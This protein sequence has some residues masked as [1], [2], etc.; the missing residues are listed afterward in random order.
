MVDI[1]RPRWA[2]SSAVQVNVS[3]RARRGVRIRRAPPRS[4]WPPPRPGLVSVRASP[5]LPK[6]GSASPKVAPA[7]PA[8]GAPA[9]PKAGS[10]R[11]LESSEAKGSSAK[12]SKAAASDEY[13]LN[14]NKALDKKHEGKTFSEIIKLPPS[15]LQGLA[16]KVS[17]GERKQ[18]AGS[19]LSGEAWLLS[20]PRTRA[21]NQLGPLGEQSVGRL[22]SLA[23][24]TD[25][26]PHAAVPFVLL[27]L[28]SRSPISL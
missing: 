28:P 7:S 3:L 8:S 24:S 1:M 20:P 27:C 21:R 13:Q 10:K 18:T 11:A 6:A 2:L 9:S 16:G 25:P 14:F 4:R 26:D 5:A 17:R 12:K 23:D 22:S 15:A 19:D